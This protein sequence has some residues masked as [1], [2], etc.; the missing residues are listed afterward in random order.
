V[1][2]VLRRAYRVAGATAARRHLQAV[3]SWLEANSHPDVAASLLEG[4]EET[5][6]VLKLE[7]PSTLRRFFATTNCI[8]N[9]IAT[10]RH[11]TRNVNRWRWGDMI[12]RWAGLGLLR[13]AARFRRIKHHRE[14]HLVRA[15]RLDA[16]AEMA[17]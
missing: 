11:V 12:H 1:C 17:A 2:A 9:L 15:L 6:T 3:A 7:L 13:A 4:L 14:P 16:A 8:E 5:L 10:L